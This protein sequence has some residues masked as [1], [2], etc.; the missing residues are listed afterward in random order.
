ML[1]ALRTLRR[2][3]HLLGPI[4]LP[5]WPIRITQ[6]RR[7][8]PLHHYRGSALLLPHQTPLPA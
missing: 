5:T 6:S 7:Y 2:E 8:A 3:K 1:C 4:L